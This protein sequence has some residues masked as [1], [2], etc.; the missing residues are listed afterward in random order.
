MQ[1]LREEIARMASS[2]EAMLSKQRTL[3]EELEKERAERRILENRVHALEKN[4][5][6]GHA[7]DGTSVEESQ[8]PSESA[9][10]GADDSETRTLRSKRSDTIE[11]T[12]N[13]AQIELR[14]AHA[15]LLDDTRT[16]MDGCDVDRVLEKVDRRVASSVAMEVARS[17][18]RLSPFATWCSSDSTPARGQVKRHAQE[19]RAGSSEQLRLRQTMEDVT[20]LSKELSG[21]GIRESQQYTL[22]QCDC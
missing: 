16:L 21:Q 1:Q 8:P 19:L 17:T 9:Y 18:L 7:R 14:C 13:L 4:S 12:Q 6:T 3:E 10:V 15:W 2:Q 11:A 22:L 20:S 5:S